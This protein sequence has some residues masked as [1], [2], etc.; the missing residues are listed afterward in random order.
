[1]NLR[2]IRHLNNNIH[3]TKSSGL[4]TTLLIYQSSTDPNQHNEPFNLDY[5]QVSRSA[6]Y[7]NNVKYF[8]VQSDR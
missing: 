6:G 1:M 7:G 8:V 4:P 5:S 3:T 2:A